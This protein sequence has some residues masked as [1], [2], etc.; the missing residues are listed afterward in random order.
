[1]KLRIEAKTGQ[2]KKK[3]CSMKK[4]RGNNFTLLYFF[5]YK[6]IYKIFI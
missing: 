2:K 1:M 5:S 4:V 3:N 6:Y